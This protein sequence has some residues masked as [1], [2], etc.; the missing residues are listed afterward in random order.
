[1]ARQRSL[2]RRGKRSKRK[3]GF[4]QWSKQGIYHVTTWVG[5]LL[6]RV[7]QWLWSVGRR[8]TGWVVNQFMGSVTCLICHWVGVVMSTSIPLSVVPHLIPGYN[9]SSIPFMPPGWGGVMVTMAIALLVF[10]R[11][12]RLSWRRSRSSLGDKMIQACG[13]GVIWQYTRVRKV[14]SLMRRGDKS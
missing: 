9:V 6:K 4:W 2:R 12:G 3:R 1:M 13:S 8:V 5:D 7:F 11:G 10:K 14:S